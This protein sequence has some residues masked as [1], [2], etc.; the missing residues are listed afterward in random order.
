MKGKAAVAGISFVLLASLC[1]GMI[2]IITIQAYRGGINV[3]TLLSLRYLIAS[4]ITVPVMRLVFKACL[5]GVGQ[6]VKIMLASGVL[7]GLEAALYFYALTRLPVSLAALLL[8]TFPILVYAI[9]LC[10]GRVK[11]T[12][13]G[14]LAMLLSIA[15]LALMLGVSQGQADALGILCALLAS[16]AYAVYLI[17]VDRLTRGVHPAATN[18]LVSLGNAAVLTAA[19]LATG[20]FSIHFSGGVWLYVALLIVVSNL[21]G[22]WI[23]Y[24][25]L[26]ILGPTVTSALNMTEPVFASALSWML[27]GQGMST[28][29]IIGGTMVLAGILSF[30]LHRSQLRC[31]QK[32]Y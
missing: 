15:G 8:F 12:V 32:S 23:F 1:F 9:E 28:M 22:F 13:V 10:L 2:P 31:L 3:L 11:L 30:S 6:S 16:A 18:A 19:A 21:I 17:L 27:L 25:G 26:G 29:G 7:M 5:P 4:A 24:R 20:T 14:G